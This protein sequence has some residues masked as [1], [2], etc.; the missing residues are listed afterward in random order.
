MDLLEYVPA[1]SIV[2]LIVYH[3]IF[4]YRSTNGPPSSSAPRGTGWNSGSDSHGNSATPWNVVG[5]QPGREPGLDNE[6]AMSGW[7]SGG[8]GGGGGSSGSGGNGGG[9]NGTG[10]GWGSAPGENRGTAGSWNR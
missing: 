5:R 9:A 7:G 10:G 1:T 3:C 2:M 4:H 8:G 6:G